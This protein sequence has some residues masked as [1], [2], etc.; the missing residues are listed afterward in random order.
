MKNRNFTLSTTFIWIMVIISLILTIIGALAIIRQ[1]QLV[2]SQWIIG[3]ALLILA[4][5]IIIID[6]NRNG[7]FNKRFWI[8]S[9]LIIPSITSIFYLIQRKKLIELGKEFRH[10]SD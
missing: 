3:F 9:M 7:I 6:M 4:W 2:D 1:W 5:A 10:Q 8:L